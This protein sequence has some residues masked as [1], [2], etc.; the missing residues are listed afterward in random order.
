[1]VIAFLIGT[2]TGAALLYWYN[3]V[4]ARKS[5]RIPKEWPLQRRP[6]VNSVE[7]RVWIWLG[8]T[9]F[10]QQ[11]LV[12]LPVT[13]FTAPAHMEDAAYWYKLLNGLYCTFTVC[14]MDGKVI[15][16]VDVAGHQGLSMS[17]QTL[18]HGLLTQCGVHYWIVDP[19]NLPPLNQVRAAFLGERA[20]RRPGLEDMEARSTETA[21]NPRP[22]SSGS[23][24]SHFAQV[25]SAAIRPDF[26]DSRL[27]S[28]WEANSFVTP[29][30]SR[31]GDL[32]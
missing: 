17:N 13:R 25:D 27:T 24:S 6:L 5:R 30:D 32:H 3:R 11:I 14:S 29:L 10:D 28:A 22:A 2:V 19:D 16:C 1:M 18:K 7:Q 12:K 4:T 23:E 8:K 15:G 9:M 20:L 31:S 26:P 21:G